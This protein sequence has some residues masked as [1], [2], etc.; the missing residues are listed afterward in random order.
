MSDFLKVMILAVVQGVTEFLPI[1]SSGHLVVLEHVMGLEDAEQNLY[2]T[3][4]L[5]AGT[6]LAIL[7]YYVK[8]LIAL[9]RKRESRVILLIMIGT[10]PIVLVGLFLESYIEDAFGNLWFTILS[11][12]LT[13]LLLLLLHKRTSGKVE[14][15]TMTWR[16]ALAIGLMQCVAV[17]PGVSRSGSTISTATRCGLTGEAAARFS[18]FLGIPAIGGATLLKFFDVVRAGSNPTTIALPTL[19]IGFFV[20]FVVGYFS[21]A[22][23]IRTLQ[24]GKFHY[25]GYYCLGL[26][27]FLLIMNVAA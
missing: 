13:A 24:G 22:L 21:L 5:H 4:L 17:L 2:L 10:A 15:E 9:I 14:M 20:S 23:L 26:A 27:L 18:F 6:L 1:S 25:F 8:D 11:F 19:V 3:I 16:A 7:V 12:L